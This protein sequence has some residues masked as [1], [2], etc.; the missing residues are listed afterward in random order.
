LQNLTTMSLGAHAV[1]FGTRLRDNRDANST[2]AGF[3]G[4]FSFASLDAYNNATAALGSGIPSSPAALPADAT[5]QTAEL[6][7]RPAGARPTSSTRRSSC[8]TT[9]RPTRC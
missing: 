1:K 8:R 4:S 2:N 6:H 9:G 5:P 7:H 3:N